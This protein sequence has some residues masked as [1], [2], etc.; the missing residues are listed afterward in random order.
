MGGFAI[1]RYEFVLVIRSERNEDS[2]FA[3]DCGHMV[4][5]DPGVDD[6]LFEGKSS[7]NDLR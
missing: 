1:G 3:S 6:A 2:D 5:K 7:W 4:R